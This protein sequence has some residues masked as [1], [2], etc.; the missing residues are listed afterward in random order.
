[1]GL[2]DRLT[3][4]KTEMV[5]D[6][7]SRRFVKKRPQPGQS[8]ARQE[9]P[10]RRA[11]EAYAARDGSRLGKVS[12]NSGATELVPVVGESFYQD[13]ISAAVGRSGSQRVEKR[14]IAFLWADDENAYDKNA[15]AVTVGRHQ[16][17]FLPADLAVEFR[18]AVQAAR[19]KRA[20][21]E[22]RALVR[23]SAPGEWETTNA[24]VMLQ[25]T[26]PQE[27]LEIVRAFQAK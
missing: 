11:A 16:V 19:S 17:G 22:C 23:A 7:P 10:K 18:P 6:R 24:G 13:G 5:W 15:V 25:L 20:V 12:V 4:R 1:M 8:R 14:V 2:W 27:T 3:G 9:D 26:S 21:I